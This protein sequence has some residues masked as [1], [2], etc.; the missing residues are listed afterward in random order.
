[1]KILQTLICIITLYWPAAAQNTVVRSAGNITADEIVARLTENNHQR[2]QDLQAYTGQRT[3]HLLYTGFLGRHEAELIVE[4]R[5]QAPGSKSFTTISQSGS[6]WVVS[7]VFKRLLETEKDAT[8][9]K[10]QASTALSKEN[11]EFE[12]L[13]QEDIDGR[14]SY[15]LKV[16]PKTA[17]KL[18]YRGR[19]WI[20]AADFALARVEAEPAKRPSFWISKTVVHHTYSKIGEFWLPVQNEST[21]EVGLGG[22]ATLS[23]RYQ[24]YR[25]VSKADSLQPGAPEQRS[26]NFVGNLNGSVTMPRVP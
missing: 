3:Y 25:V 16:E 5:Y 23:I 10:S 11:Y 14:I 21:T 6:G 18:L 17:S 2:Q 7:H 9:E 24:D 26:A 22:H 8:D 20:D 15:V 19:I 13:G 1:M 4:A 12:L